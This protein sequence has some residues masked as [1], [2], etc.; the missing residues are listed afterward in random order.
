MR[1]VRAFAF[2]AW[3]KKSKFQDKNFPKLKSYQNAL[4]ITRVIFSTLPIKK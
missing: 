1:G 2:V 4:K 3:T